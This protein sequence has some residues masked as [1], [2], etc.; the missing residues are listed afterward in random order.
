MNIKKVALFVVVGLIVFAGV[1]YGADKYAE[2][3]P[4]IEKMAVSFEKF[5]NGMEEAENADAVA[6]ALDDFT[7]VM[8]D[9]VPKVIELKKKYPE[10]KEEKNYPEELKPLLKK[11]DKLGKRIFGVIRKF[12]Q[13][14]ND[15]KVKEAIK[16]M[17]TMDFVNPEPE[18]TKEEK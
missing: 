6:A 4:I 16:R 13:F 11:I 1:V 14:R 7:K 18:K 12:K 2:I 5:I 10:L 9:F 3:K 17:E 8:K 15:P